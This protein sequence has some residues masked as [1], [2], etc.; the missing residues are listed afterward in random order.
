MRTNR[1]LT[2]ISGVLASVLWLGSASAASIVYTDSV[3]LDSDWELINATFGL[4]GTSSATQVSAGGFPGEYREIT[5]SVNTAADSTSAAIWGFHR[6][7]GATYDPSSQGAIYQIDYSEDALLISG[8]GEGQATG[9]AL[10]QGGL[11]YFASALISPDFDW[12]HKELFGLSALAFR[13]L[14]DGSQYPDFSATGDI[15]ELGFFRANSTR[16]SS[17]TIL[18][19]I[20][21]W[22]F[23]IHTG[24]D[25][26]NETNDTIPASVPETGT[27]GLFGLA[28]L[29]LFWRR[30]ASCTSSPSFRRRGQSTAR[31]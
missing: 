9:P 24:N 26:G 31:R 29:G 23:T 1:P 28:C 20:D 19:G 13:L 30:F 15:I 22:S 7:I 5:T 11:I 21:N 25:T 14:T 10:R 16:G 27:A 8:F 2:L 12:I 6:N 18:G 4:G 3:F 17:Y